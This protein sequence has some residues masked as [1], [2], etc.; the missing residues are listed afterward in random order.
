M[1][2]WWCCLPGAEVVVG[3]I[4]LEEEE[5]VVSLSLAADQWIIGL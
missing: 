2:W 1:G 3:S 5:S 4:E